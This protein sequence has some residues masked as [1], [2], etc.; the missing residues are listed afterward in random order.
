M[1]SSMARPTDSPITHVPNP[2]K[3]PT[4]APTGPPTAKPVK[5]H[6]P[7]FPHFPIA[8]P[9]FYTRHIQIQP[10]LDHKQSLLDWQHL[11]LS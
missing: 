6:M 1:L 11:Q 2:V 3:A 8:F 4:A 7:M 10:E 9:C 5:A